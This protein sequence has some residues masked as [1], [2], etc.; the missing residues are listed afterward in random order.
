MMIKTADPADLPDTQ[1]RKR[2]SPGITRYTEKETPKIS[3]DAN[4]DFSDCPR[5]CIRKVCKPARARRPALSDQSPRQSRVYR[6]RNKCPRV[7]P[8]KKV[9]PRPRNSQCE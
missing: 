5:L 9:F 4:R 8:W 1:K 3:S 6:P 2:R 7:R